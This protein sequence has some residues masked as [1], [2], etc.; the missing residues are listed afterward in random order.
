MNVAVLSTSSRK[1]G[2]LFYSVRWLS[3]AL[4]SLGCNPR[5]YSPADEYSEE[6]LEVWEPI[7]V[8]L[9]SG[10]GPLQ[11]SFGLRGQLASS[12]V[13]LIHLHG[14]WLDNQWAAMHC[15]KKTGVPVVVSPR[16]MLDPWAVQNAAWKKRLVEMLFA[17]RA[18]KQASCIH[19]LCRSEVESI[20]AYGLTNPVALI[21]NGVEL[22]EIRNSKITDKPQRE[23]LFLGRI[24]PKK[25]LKELLQAWALVSSDWK[26]L[27]AG[28]DD[29]GHES[30]LKAL[31]HELGVE[32][33]VEFIG[34]QYGEKKAELLQRVDAFVL[35]SFSEGLP[36]SVLEAW[37]YGLPVM[38]SDFCNIPEGF[39][40]GAALRVEPNVESV[41]EGLSQLTVMT[42]E[43]LTSMG[44]KGRKLVEQKFT[45]SKI[46]EEMKQVY[47]W[48][49]DGGTP[50]D[51]V[52]LKVE[53]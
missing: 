37:S 9:Y 47:S 2:G 5:V 23:L 26:L 25:G 31:V 15:Q 40:A 4:V 52:E 32:D 7:P 18:L 43:Q 21:P 35:P 51:C 14:I 13:D 38:M 30:G 20:R 6:D 11:T 42:H 44:S 49:L 33:S 16:G 8:E 24:H 1:A 10:F 29:G 39:D 45:W 53:T 41:A 48:C 46:A 3:K 27:I 22:P 28:W 12:S 17:R 50:P 36:M 19:A 34:P